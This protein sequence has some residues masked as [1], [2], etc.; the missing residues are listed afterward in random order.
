MRVIVAGGGTG[1]HLFPCLAV[2]E[3]LLREGHE[4][5]YVGSSA[6]I[7]SK[8]RELLPSD[9]IFIDS[10]GIRGKGIKGLING[11]LL[12]K[13]V[14][15]AMSIV[16]SFK[17]DKVVLFGGYVSLPLGI[18]AAVRRMPLILQEQNSIPGKT[19]LF[20]SRFS[21]K[22]LVGYRR[23]VQFFRDKAVFT[24]NPVRNEII[25]AAANRKSLRK[26]VYSVL[27]LSGKKKTLLIVGGSQGAL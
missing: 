16:S 17:P 11:F 23:A 26:E 24:G 25:E 13:A 2:S 15:Q 21:K 4:V 27:G 19:N 7:E 20:L 12:L 14:R 5:L 8:R 6:G 3:R 1:G 22:V 18:A 10:R 9:F